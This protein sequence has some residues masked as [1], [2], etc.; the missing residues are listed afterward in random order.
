MPLSFS[1]PEVHASKQAPS[2]PKVK[3]TPRQAN[4]NQER[5][6][7]KKGK[8]KKRTAPRGLHVKRPDI[9][10]RQLR[11]PP[12]QRDEAADQAEGGEEEGVSRANLSLVISRW[13]GV[14]DGGEEGMGFVLT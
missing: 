5:E 10:P 11:A 7:K 9:P 2:P 6:E 1:L 8:R 13:F 12:A 3:S 14:D 4:V